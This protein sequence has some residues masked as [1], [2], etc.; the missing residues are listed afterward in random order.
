MFGKENVPSANFDNT[1]MMGQSVILTE[2]PRRWVFWRAAEAEAG[3]VTE[4]PLEQ[5]VRAV[6][7]AEQSTNSSLDEP[8]SMMK[9]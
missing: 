2:A 6:P 8:S 5:E 9:P 3:A 1:P 4:R 7:E